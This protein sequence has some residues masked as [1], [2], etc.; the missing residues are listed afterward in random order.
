MGNIADAIV[1][2]A[3]DDYETYTLADKV[4][5]FE[6]IQKDVMEETNKKEMNDELLRR[7][8]ADLNTIQSLASQ[9][10]C[11]MGKK[12]SD[13]VIISTLKRDKGCE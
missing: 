8:G 12:N 2:Q 7:K 5:I 10:V 4:N 11:S 13:P 3:S 6:I 9:S 1:E